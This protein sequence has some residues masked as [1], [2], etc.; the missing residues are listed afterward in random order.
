MN[1]GCT[2]IFFP[3]PLKCVWITK[4]IK[5][6]TRKTNMYDIHFKNSKT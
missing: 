1:Q 2:G 3:K 4:L 6:Y 5:N